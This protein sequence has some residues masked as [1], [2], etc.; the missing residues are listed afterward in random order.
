M[1]LPAIWVL[2]AVTVGG[3]IMGIVG[4]LLGVPIAASVYRLIREDVNR[5]SKR[6]SIA[7]SKK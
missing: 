6:R 2:S 4:M 3:G 5:I 7:T 1:G